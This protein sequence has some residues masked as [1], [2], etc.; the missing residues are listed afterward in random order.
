MFECRHQPVHLPDDVARELVA[1]YSEPHRAYHNLTHIAEL[2]GWFDRVA[3][4]IG[5]KDP[6]AVYAAI[7]FHDAIYVPGAKDN[8]ARSADWARRA[9]FG[10][11]VA[12]LILMTMSHTSHGD[13]GHDAAH[14]LDADM[15]IVGAPAEQFAAYDAAIARE[16]SHVPPDAFRAGRKA[17]LAGLA[18]LPRIFITEYFHSRLDAQARANLAAA[19]RGM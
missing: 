6:A 15:A 11:D 12:Q 4:D 18:K 19:I 5:W 14:F 7:V 2:L 8:E 9:G 16:Y 1:A 17:F 10:D 3:D 13:A